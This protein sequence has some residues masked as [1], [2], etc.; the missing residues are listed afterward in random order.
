MHQIK[1]TNY[2]LLTIL[3]A[4]LFIV[5]T[6]CQPRKQD[7]NSVK[8]GTFYFYPDRSN[9]RFTIIRQDNLQK[10]INLNTGDTSFWRIDWTTDCSF[11]A[12]YLYGGSLKSDKDKQFL[13]DHTTLVNI[14]ATTK[15][16]F[17]TKM[18]LDSI[19]SP[20]TSTDTTWLTNKLNSR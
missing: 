8:N 4:L 6:D 9:D 1:K 13:N 12:K 2:S 19:S 17:I 20:F 5:F 10:E 16:Y 15:E 7:C 14:L 11:T 18:S 3:L